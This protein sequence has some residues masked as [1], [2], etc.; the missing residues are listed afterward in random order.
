MVFDIYSAWREQNL[1]DSMKL[2]EKISTWKPDEKEALLGLFWQAD[3]E[4]FLWTIRWKLT[5]ISDE[6]RSQVEKIIGTPISRLKESHQKKLIF[7]PKKIDLGSTIAYPNPEKFT[8][9]ELCLY[10]SWFFLDKEVSQSMV[11]L[12][13]QERAQQSQNV[14]INLLNCYES[15]EVA[16]TPSN[17][18]HFTN[19]VLK[20]F[21]RNKD[22]YSLRFFES[23]LVD[24]PDIWKEIDENDSEPSAYSKTE[25]SEISWD[26]KILDLPEKKLKH[27]IEELVQKFFISS[28]I[29][30]AKLPEN[31]E[32]FIWIRPNIFLPSSFQ[33]QFVKMKELEILLGLHNYYEQ[34]ESVLA[35]LVVF[36]NPWIVQ[37]YWV[38][39]ATLLR[40]KDFQR[41]PSPKDLWQQIQG[42]QNTSSE[43]S[44]QESKENIPLYVLDT[45]FSDYYW[46]P[47][48]VRLRISN[49][50]WLYYLNLWDDEPIIFRFEWKNI[51]MTA[52][53]FS[54]YFHRNDIPEKDEVNN[55]LDL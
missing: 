44:V 32:W 30:S 15:E 20:T 9:N 4:I 40:K 50:N 37:K 26:S 46:F 18:H 16:E 47:D 14:S 43:T 51:Q 19:S 3:P 29:E 42:V 10:V 33:T 55:V 13:F 28:L 49:Q 27:N 53:E 41:Y 25:T 7:P 22:Q 23:E 45:R 35:M 11:Q 8:Q 39:K 54:R 31:I 21:E 17:I 24:F 48:G 12:F 1:D 5:V 36:Y 38:Q 52:K 2:V 34:R 6:K